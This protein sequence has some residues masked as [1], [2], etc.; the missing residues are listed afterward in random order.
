MSP[1]GTTV[2]PTLPSSFSFP[3]PPR[4]EKFVSSANFSLLLLLSP[5]SGF[6]RA[7]PEYNIGPFFWLLTRFKFD[8]LSPPCD[9]NLYSSEEKRFWYEK[10]RE[11][12]GI[13][14]KYVEKSSGWEKTVRFRT[15]V[16][17]FPF[18]FLSSEEIRFCGQLLSTFLFLLFSLFA[19]SLLKRT[20][21][22]SLIRAAAA[23]F[24]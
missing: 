10:R 7:P 18:P 15:R 2:L 8:N 13:W 4:L 3:P 23:E 12:D 20:A 21:S 11:R 19:V 1:R 6:L 24:D 16:T 9:E 17:T 5:F 22:G 14:K